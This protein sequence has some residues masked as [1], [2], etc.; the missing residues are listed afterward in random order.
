MHSEYWTVF[1]GWAVELCSVCIDPADEA[2]K[3]HKSDHENYS[4]NVNYL[5]ILEN[6]AGKLYWQ[7]LAAPNEEI[8]TNKRPVPVSGAT[9]RGPPASPPQVP[10]PPAVDVQIVLGMTSPAYEAKHCS[11]GMIMLRTERRTGEVAIDP[12]EVLPQPLTVPV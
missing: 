9:V 3:N 1:R 12:S 7:P 6:A 5:E 11:F 4:K 2:S 10:C 8:P